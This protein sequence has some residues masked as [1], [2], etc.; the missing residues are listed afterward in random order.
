MACGW[1]ITGRDPIQY[2]PARTDPDDVINVP[3][4][5]GG[6]VEWAELAGY[7]LRLCSQAMFS[8]Y[9]LTSNAKREGGKLVH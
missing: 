7:A 8:G 6:V 2:R 5:W 1:L 9:A 3:R 4:G